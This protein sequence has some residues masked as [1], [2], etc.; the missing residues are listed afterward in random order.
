MKNETRT[1]GRAPLERRS[2]ITDEATGRKYLAV[3]RVVGVYATEAVVIHKGL[4]GFLSPQVILPTAALIG[5]RQ[6]TRLDKQR[7]K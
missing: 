3:D 4:A 6:L 5:A 2:E 7:K 1:F